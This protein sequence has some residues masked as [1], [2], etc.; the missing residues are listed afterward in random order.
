[1]LKKL[2]ISSFII[3]FLVSVTGLPVSIHLCKMQE[4]TGSKECPMCSAGEAKPIPSGDEAALSKI[5][6]TCCKTTVVDN[7]VKDEFFPTAEQN[8]GIYSFIAVA[9]LTDNIIS[10]NTHTSFIPESPPP[11]PGS[12][13]TF[14]DISILLI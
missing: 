8:T 12:G 4:L 11:S 6:N 5:P 7:K 10:N 9:V 13:K 1:M 3:L 14:I 2:I